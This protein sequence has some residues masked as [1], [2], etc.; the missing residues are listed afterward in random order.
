MLAAVM[1]V[2]PAHAGIVAGGSVPVINQWRGIGVTGLDVA[3]KGDTV[4]LANI[5]I[6][7]NT[8]NGFD[9]TI[10]CTNGG[11]GL[12][13][14]TAVVPFT[15][16][17]ADSTASTQPGTLGTG[18][19]TSFATDLNITPGANATATYSSGAQT[20]ATDGYQLDLFGSWAAS[21]TLL[22]GYYTESFTISMKAK[23]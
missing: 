14:D 16:L 6:D 18:A 23:L 1:S 5:W 20:T 15:A 7:N 11:F 4:T 21:T 13:G 3:S 8:A 9:L 22:A 10:T 19:A 2:V 12:P 17:W